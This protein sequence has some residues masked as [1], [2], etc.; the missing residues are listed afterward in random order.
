MNMNGILEQIQT[1][2]INEAMF[3]L[4]D[5]GHVLT[6]TE[7]LV[8]AVLCAVGVLFCLLGLKIVRFWAVLVGLL[9]G[10]AGGTA[11][12]YYLGMNESY[13]W[14]PGVV[15]GVVL[16]VLGAWRY[17]FG[18][19]LTVWA[20]AGLT[21]VYII[22]PADWVWGA[23]CLAAGLVL[24]VLAMRF[25]TLLTM[26]VTAVGGA[27]LGGTAAYF[28]TSFRGMAIHIVI[29][30]V[31]GILGFLVQLLLESRKRKKQNLK[32]AAEIRDNQST[33]NE[34]EKARA[35]VDELDEEN[36]E[37]SEE[38]EFI[39]FDA[40]SDDEEIDDLE[41]DEEIDY[42]DNEEESDDLEDDEEID[43]LDEEEIEYLDEE[44]EEK[45]KN[46]TD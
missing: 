35:L 18:V 23:V 14:I 22:R 34:V 8:L 29:C 24:A 44:T 30:T 41:D 19:F 17:R 7:T 16:A 37:E 32:K 45:L 27:V 40:E 12:A 36:V 43:Y 28:L 10:L 33:E 20:S 4:E 11:A 5:A 6:Q 9:L 2:N 26:I 1:F 31:L 21:C 42:L 38:L 3:T 13:I 25:I 15:L 39:Q 46:N